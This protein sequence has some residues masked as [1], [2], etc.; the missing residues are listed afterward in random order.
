MNKYKH[1]FF[2]LDRTL[3]DFDKSSYQTFE[4]LYKVFT[5]KER[6][7]TSIEKFYDTYT[8]I[9]TELWEKY[10][11]GEMEKAFL[12]VHRFYLTFMEF[13]IENNTLA[14]KFANQYLALAPL[15][16]TLFPGAIEVLES[17]KGRY[18]L[19]IITN[20]FEEVQET[21]IEANGLKKF[22]KT[23]TTSEEAGVKKPSEGIFL[24]AFEK[25]NARADESI[26]IGDDFEVDILGAKNVGMDQIF[27]NNNGY[28]FKDEAT[29]EV[30]KML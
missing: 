19:H 17:L 28:S 26:M 18:N 6:G 29:F 12:N 9:N 20:G 15:K 1:I 2:D 23:I 25:A 5:L 7:V 3:Y 10:R 14:E 24:F 4:E 27:F 11:K 30:M 8:K 16:Q 21:K 22:F 13:G